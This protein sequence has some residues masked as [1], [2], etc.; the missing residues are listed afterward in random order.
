MFGNRQSF[1][2]SFSAIAPDRDSETLTR[3]QS[4]PS[5]DWGLSIK[6][7]AVR[8]EEHILVA[9]VDLRTV[10]GSSSEIAYAAG[11]PVALVNA[12][13]R[14]R[15]AGLFVQDIFPVHSRITLSAGARY[16]NWLNS[17]GV[18]TVELLSSGLIQA[19]SISPRSEASFSPRLDISFAA[20]RN[21]TLRAAAYRAF[22]APTLNELYR[23]FR[24]G[25]VFTLANEELTAEHLTGGEIGV[26]ISAF[27]PGDTRVTAFWNEISDPVSNRTISVADSLITRQ[28]IN[29]GR[30]QSR[31]LEI[32]TEWNI[33]KDFRISGGYFFA[34]ARI[35][36]APQDPTLIG[37]RIPQIPKHQFSLQAVYSNRKY[38]T[39]V[40][41]VRALSKQYDDDRNLFPLR[42]YTVFDLMVARSVAH[43]AEAFVAVQNVLNERFAVARTPV[44]NLGMPRLIRAGMRINFDR[45]F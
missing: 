30:L 17:S 41:E 19:R 43:S 25:D 16:D 45:L 3:L 8:F 18:S 38:I 35:R 14:Q 44:E 6:W 27:S 10:D 23:S 28:R 37:L 4:V 40:I 32:E 2:Q 36:Q 29:L 34:N 1:H 39:T 5:N 20:N 15:R 26:N 13:G 11:A 31:G 33:L 42:G 7:T 9:G 24:V 22:R 21:L 12:G